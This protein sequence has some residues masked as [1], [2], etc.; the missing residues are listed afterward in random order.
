MS[1]FELG[2]RKILF[3][4]PPAD[5]GVVKEADGDDGDCRNVV[6]A[7]LRRPRGGAWPGVAEEDEMGIVKARDL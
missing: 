2:M 7:G 3:Q 5:T 1:F 6:D 4:P